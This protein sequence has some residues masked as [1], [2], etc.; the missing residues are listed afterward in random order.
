M[1]NLSLIGEEGLRFPE[2]PELVKF[3]VFRPAEVTA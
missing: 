3:A 1:S 2:L